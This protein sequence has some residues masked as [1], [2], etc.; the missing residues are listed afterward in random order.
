M[1]CVCPAGE[2]GMCGSPLIDAVRKGL[3]PNS[4]VVCT[5]DSEISCTMSVSLCLPAGKYV[6]IH[7]SLYVLVQV[8]GLRYLRKFTCS[9]LGLHYH[10]MILGIQSA[11]MVHGH[12]FA[13]HQHN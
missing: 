9:Q 1:K 4:Q 12:W 10:N 13:S 11:K 5:G 2:K 3:G 6:S 8:K 7:I